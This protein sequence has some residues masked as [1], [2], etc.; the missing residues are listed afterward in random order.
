MQRE[1]LK[2]IDDQHVALEVRNAD[3]SAALC[4]QRS[5]R[6]EREKKLQLL[7]T[8]LADME[9]EH[10][11]ALIHEKCAPPDPT[12]SHPPPPYLVLLGALGLLVP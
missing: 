10:H 11:T 12:Y 3:L 9:K 7:Q 2:V 1:E 6:V 8:E 4:K 5:E